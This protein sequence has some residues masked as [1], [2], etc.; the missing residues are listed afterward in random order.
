MNDRL[1]DTWLEAQLAPRH[2]PRRISKSSLRGENFI[3]PK[4]EDIIDAK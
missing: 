1:I 4:R 2:R 3:A